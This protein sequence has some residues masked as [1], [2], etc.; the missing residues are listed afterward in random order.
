MRFL[1]IVNDNVV[2]F[3]ANRRLLLISQ[4]TF[5]FDIFQVPADIPRGAVGIYLNNNN[6]VVIH[7]TDF[8]GMTALTFIG[9]H[10]NFISQIEI[11]AFTDL[12]M[13]TEL[14][15]TNNNLRR[16]QDHV[17]KGRSEENVIAVSSLTTHTKTFITA[18]KRSLGQGNIFTP[19]CH[20]VH[21]GGGQYLTRYTPRH[22][23]HTPGT[24]PGTR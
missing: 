4:K 6:L 16:L 7:N 1:N 5:L 13:V 14:W 11:G 3:V 12:S 15:L 17:F 23:A 18:R 10:S 22:Q 9:L 8:R 20:S 19:V 2:C 24:P 21:G